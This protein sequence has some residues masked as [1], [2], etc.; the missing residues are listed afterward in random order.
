LAQQG[1][2]LWVVAF[3]IGESKMVEWASIIS[4][5]V[6]VTIVIAKACDRFEVASDF[7]GRNLPPGVK[8]ATINAM[9]SSM[10]EMLT[11]MA[12]LV[13]GVSGAFAAGVSVT[14]G[15][16]VFNSAIIPLFVILAVM[17]PHVLRLL[18]RIFTLGILIVKEGPAALSKIQV[19]KSAMA[20][21]I[22][23]LLIAEIALIFLL[24]ETV[25]YWYHG[26]FLI[27]LYFPYLL[28]MWWQTNNHE[29][30]EYDL[31]D[32]EVSNSRR[33]WS[34]LAG[35]ILVL[36]CAC[37]LLGE[38]ILEGAAMVGVHPMIS[39]LF[40]GAAVSSVP[41]TI[42]SVKDALK[43]NYEDALG[44]ALGS[45]TFDICAALGV[46]LFIYALITGPI[47]MPD[48]D[49]IQVLR[50]GLLIF[51]ILI[52]ALLL[53]PKFIRLWHAKAL[54]ITYIVWALFALNT[55]FNWISF[56]A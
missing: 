50:V 43:G 41:D 5:I 46:P 56:T 22:I 11:T 37:Y 17:A 12:L 19:D 51:T 4:L 6:I 15:S 38:A 40:L 44:N 21:D 3:F 1:G 30:E 28:F 16:A 29:P 7:L 13:I 25:L 55:E 24:G 27:C 8:G 33:A 23:A 39:A 32:F 54:F 2:D 48:H 36:V 47:Q 34:I 31:D 53:I 18:A 45:N 14:A 52:A 20:R 42:L 26:L 49:A 9:G 10:P 35:S